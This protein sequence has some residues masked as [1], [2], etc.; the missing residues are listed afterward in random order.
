VY[1]PSTA[2]QL[3]GHIGNSFGFE[4]CLCA[5]IREAALEGCFLDELET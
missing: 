3:A 5:P 4:T 1:Q 2:G